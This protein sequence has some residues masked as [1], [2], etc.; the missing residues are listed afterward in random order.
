MIKPCPFCG[1]KAEIRSKPANRF[2]VA[3][4][5]RSCG[6]VIASSQN[7]QEAMASWNRRIGGEAADVSGAEPGRPQ[8]NDERMRALR[9]ELK[10]YVA[11]K[12]PNIKHLDACNWAF[13]PLHPK[14]YLGVD[15]WYLL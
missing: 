15:F 7:E 11:K 8:Y 3:C 5:S 14:N 13:Y 9:D 1:A 4:S 12:Y 6:A 2:T 10:G